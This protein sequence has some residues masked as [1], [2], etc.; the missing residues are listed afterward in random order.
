M[1]KLAVLFTLIFF[2]AIALYAREEATVDTYNLNSLK[3]NENAMTAS[4]HNNH[5]LIVHK[6]HK[7]QNSEKEKQKISLTSEDLSKEKQESAP[8]C[9]SYDIMPK[10]EMA[11]MP[12]TAE[13]EYKDRANLTILKTRK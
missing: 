7:N 12:C 4:I 11:Y 6:K 3:Y 10:I 8:E 2:A 13:P 9:I 5:R 1:K